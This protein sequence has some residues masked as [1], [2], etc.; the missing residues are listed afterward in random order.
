MAESED[1]K[2]EY[3]QSYDNRTLHTTEV[4]NSQVEFH[5]VL[6]HLFTAFKRMN[7]VR[8]NHTVGVPRWLFRLHKGE[9]GITWHP[10]SRI[11]IDVENL[12]AINVC[13]RSNVKHLVAVE[14]LGRGG[15]G[16]VWLTCTV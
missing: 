15:S 5:Y 3:L 16:K 13:S 7:E 11:P 4:L 14:D 8:L 12:S 6:R 9:E 1:E 10:I 2:E